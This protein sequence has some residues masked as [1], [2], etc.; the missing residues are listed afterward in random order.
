[1][2]APRNRTGSRREVRRSL[3]RS[4]AGVLGETSAR[5]EHR[6]F[7]KELL[8]PGLRPHRAVECLAEFL[9]VPGTYL[10]MACVG[11]L[12]FGADACTFQ[13]EVGNVHA[14]MFGAQANEP[15]FSIAEA[16]VQ[17]L[18]A[19]LA[20]CGCRHGRIP[21]TYI[22]RFLYIQCTLTFR[23]RQTP[24]RKVAGPPGESQAS[25]KC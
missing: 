8:E 25:K 19:F 3:R 10:K 20:G 11:D 12:L 13:N 9:P 24:E 21:C 16:N 23:L 18:R 15:G 7:G 17:P 14:P 4:I 2:H 5:F 22:N 1:I 6:G